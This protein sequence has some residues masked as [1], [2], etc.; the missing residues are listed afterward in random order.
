MKVLCIGHIS[1]D[2]TFPV[3]NF[4]KENTKNRVSERIEC[5]GGPASNAAYLLSLWGINT[6]FAGVVGNDASLCR[7]A[8]PCMP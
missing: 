1:Y 2:I 4:I 6:Y 7:K 8:F 3:E 5:G